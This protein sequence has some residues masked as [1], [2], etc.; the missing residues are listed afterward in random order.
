MNVGLVTATIPAIK[1]PTKQ[2][3]YLVI[4]LSSKRW[5]NTG[6]NITLEWNI[7]AASPRGMSVADKLYIQEV[8]TIEQAHRR[9]RS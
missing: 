3:W 4:F 6:L 7:A 1:A 2:I 9:V 5:L 8:I